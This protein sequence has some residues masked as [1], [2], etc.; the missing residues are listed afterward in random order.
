VC[1]GREPL[2]YEIGRPRT[3]ELRRDR[4]DDKVEQVLELSEFLQTNPRGTN[5]DFTDIERIVPLVVSPF[6]EWLWDR[7][8]R[9]W[10]SDGTPRILSAN[11]A[12]DLVE[13]ARRKA[14]S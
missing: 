9:L 14:G 3:F 7:S 1:V 12:L 2:N 8:E 13:R 11:E 10:L 6:V 5:Y 4:L